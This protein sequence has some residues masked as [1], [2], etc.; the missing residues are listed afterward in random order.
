MQ[1]QYS[2]VANLVI[3]INCC[4]HHHHQ[5]VL[6]C[7]PA[8]ACSQQQLTRLLVNSPVS[9]AS[10]APTLCRSFA[11]ERSAAAL[12]MYNTSQA[13]P[14]AAPMRSQLDPFTS[15]K[16]QP[17]NH[18]LTSN[19]QA[20]PT[21]DVAQNKP[22]VDKAADPSLPQ[23]AASRISEA[24]GE[25]SLG[26][27]VQAPQQSSANIQSSGK[28]VGAELATVL[29]PR[30][31]LGLK[32]ITAPS[33]Y[34]AVANVARTL[35]RSSLPASAAQPA[36]SGQLCGRA[37]LSAWLLCLASLHYFSALPLCLPSLHCFS[38]LLLY[39]VT[40]SR[41]CAWAAISVRF[42]G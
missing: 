11:F 16:D 23:A 32:F 5:Q 30:M 20:Q 12:L 4:N 39:I 34:T 3:I 26:K 21:A 8:Q 40:H 31:P 33:T 10:W 38:A 29:L 22:H 41:H 18:A 13:G 24:P 1:L 14:H 25:D 19:Q 7:L 2:P 15:H 36:Q 42:R 37:L 9:A 27:G 35:G 6:R 17:A 28:D